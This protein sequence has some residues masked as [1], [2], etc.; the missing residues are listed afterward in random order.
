MPQPV[1]NGRG[2][3]QSVAAPL[4]RALLLE[5][6]ERL[7]AA[8]VAIGRALVQLPAGP[9]EDCAQAICPSTLLC[10][11]NQGAGAA[12]AGSEAVKAMTN[13]TTRMGKTRLGL[14]PLYRPAPGLQAPFSAMMSFAQASSPRGRASTTAACPPSPVGGAPSRRMQ[15]AGLPESRRLPERSRQ[16]QTFSASR[17]KISTV[18]GPMPSKA[19]RRFSRSLRSLASSWMRLTR[20]SYSSISLPLSLSSRSAVDSS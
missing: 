16:R 7:C 1:G 17:M 6:V 2:L 13:R 5:A 11:L 3:P 12:R 4:R 20:P 18:F 10:H 9:G 19:C 14:R 8:Q 15:A